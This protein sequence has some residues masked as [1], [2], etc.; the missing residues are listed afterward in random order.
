M[1]FEKFSV[2][3]TPEETLRS[4]Q[5]KL[6][7]MFNK[8]L[9]DDNISSTSLTLG[10]AQVKASNIDFG[11]GA[12]QVDASD[13]PIIDASSYFVG[14]TV[15]L[16]LQQLGSTIL[17]LPAENIKVVDIGNYFTSTSVEGVLQEIGSTLT[18]IPT[19]NLSLNVQ[20]PLEIVNSTVQL[21]YNPLN[22]TINASSQLDTIQ[23]IATTDSPIFAS[24]VVNELILST[25]ID[26][27]S[28][29]QGTIYWDNQDETLSVVMAGGNVIQQVGQELYIRAV[30]KTL[31]TITNGSI[32]YISGAQGNRPT[33]EL[34]NAN[35]YANSQKVIGLATED[36]LVDAYGYVTIEGLVRDLDT[37]TH[38]DGDCLYLSTNSGQWSTTPPANGLARI[39]VGMVTK[40]HPTDGW[41][42]VKINEDK[43]MFGNP[44]TGNYSYFEDDGTLVF[45]GDATVFDD[46]S[47]SVL[48][49][50]VTGVGLSINSA[51]NTLDFTTGSD[52][53]DYA[54]DNYQFSHSRKNNTNVYP[55]VHWV[56]R[57]NNNPNFLI[58]Y[59]WQVN[60][61]PHTTTWS[62]YI[63]NNTAFIYT[64]G[65]I[66][67]I[68]GG[69]GIAPPTTDGLS[70]LMQIRIIRDCDNNSG[71]FPTTDLYSTTANVM[72]A[73]IHY[74]KD[75]IGSRQQFIK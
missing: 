36:I 46:V 7:Y 45:N 34:A 32:V 44:G 25:N 69:T 37:S 43:Y 42:C 48:E 4:W 23:N 2:L 73:D 8:N 27:A 10:P 65:V 3:S 51:E 54:Y 47:G 49:V 21:N 11:T 71:A 66:N 18:N 31:A 14:A 26:T 67:Q 20:T 70:G 17:N 29:R 58:K 41:V 50:Q 19:S 52:L 15:E 55:H 59:R 53:S 30:N 68:S 28:T 13:I 72:F 62:D 9:N 39:K 12:N 38:S 6:E 60:G 64:A 57:E 56:Q 40:A 63:L 33:I 61:Q 24:P 16:N 5:R 22:L 74:E 35:S 1:P 75:T